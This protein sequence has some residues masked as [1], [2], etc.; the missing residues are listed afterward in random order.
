MHLL[1]KLT[2]GHLPAIVFDH[3]IPR[4]AHHY[5]R[6]SVIDLLSRAGLSDIRAHWTNE[7]SWTV[8][9][10]KSPCTP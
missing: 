4:I 7:M 5:D 6:K 3:M 9:G 8:V 2:F 10:S 1:Q